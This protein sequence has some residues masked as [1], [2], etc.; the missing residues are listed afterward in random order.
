MCAQASRLAYIILVAEIKYNV[1]SVVCLHRFTCSISY[2][3]FYSVVDQ[4]SVNDDD[5]DDW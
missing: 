1:I 5:D 3:L 2:F 4:K